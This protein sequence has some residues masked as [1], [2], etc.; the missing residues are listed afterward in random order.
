MYLLKIVSLYNW[1][2]HRQ[3]KEAFDYPTILNIQSVKGVCELIMSNI[4]FAIK[5]L[6]HSTALKLR[7]IRIMNIK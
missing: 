4:Q 5:H 3:K 6:G 2:P 7:S 1:P